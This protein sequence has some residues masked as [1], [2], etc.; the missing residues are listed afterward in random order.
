MPLDGGIE[1]DAG[2]LRRGKTRQKRKIGRKIGKEH[3]DQAHAR[4]DR[5]QGVDA[6]WKIR[7]GKEADLDI[8][9][10][11]RGKRFGGLGKHGRL[12]LEIAGNRA[13]QAAPGRRSDDRANG[14]P[15]TARRADPARGP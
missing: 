3:G 8:I 11:R 14:R 10:T 4:G 5:R 12:H 2:E 15:A 7:R 1:H 13:D 9:D 6:G